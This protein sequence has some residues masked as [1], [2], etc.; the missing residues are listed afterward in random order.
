MA[1][2]TAPALAAAL[3]TLSAA[4]LAQ[5]PQRPDGAPRQPPQEAFAACANLRAGDACTVT[6]AGRSIDGTCAA[7]PGPQQG[8]VCRPH[9]LPSPPPGR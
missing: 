3:L 4:A 8:L 2:R 5:P 6:F 9:H 7:F 1:H